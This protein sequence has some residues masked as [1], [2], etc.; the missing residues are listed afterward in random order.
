MHE[1][2]RKIDNKGIKR[3]QKY[4]NVLKFITAKILK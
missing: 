2:G 4:I 3:N 1:K